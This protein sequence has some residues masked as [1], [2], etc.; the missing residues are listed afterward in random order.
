VQ[1][2]PND[3]KSDNFN[4][5]KILF[6][7][8]HLVNSQF[9]QVKN[10]KNVLWYCSKILQLTEYRLRFDSIYETILVELILMNY[11]TLINLL[12]NLISIQ[13]ELTTFVLSAFISYNDSFIIAHAIYSSS[14]SSNLF[15]RR[16]WRMRIQIRDLL[17]VI[18]V[19]HWFWWKNFQ[20]RFIIIRWD[21]Y[22]IFF[23]DMWLI[24]IG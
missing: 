18:D 2:F 15:Q 17:F 16:K 14:S 8:L 21:C 20:T 24:Y 5:E 6:L 4:I 9:V 23:F 10:S 3:Y 7:H 1:Y 11:S 19:D 13:F 22:F 12:I